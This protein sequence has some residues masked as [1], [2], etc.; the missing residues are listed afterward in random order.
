MM[1]EVAGVDIAGVH[2][3]RGSCRGGHCMSAQLQRK[4]QGWTSQE[5]TMTEEVAG[6]NVAGVHYDGGSC[7]GGH[8][9]SSQ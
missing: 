5:C 2:N 7:R 1:E 6:V 9:R 3:D 8:R 4:L